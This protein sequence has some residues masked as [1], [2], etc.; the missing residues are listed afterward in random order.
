ML[1]TPRSNLF[2]QVFLVSR[3]FQS[4]AIGGQY[5]K[6]RIAML[7][8][9][10]VSVAMLRDTDPPDTETRDTETPDTETPDTETP[11]TETPDMEM[12]S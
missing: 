10:V 5:V 11:D 4:V 2:Q 9:Q 1:G 8:C 3:R 12:R 7:K 6:L